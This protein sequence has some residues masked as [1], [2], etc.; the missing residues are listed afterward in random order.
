VAL[1]QEH[2]KRNQRIAREK[3]GQQC[4]TL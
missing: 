2:R 3:A 1:H 4:L